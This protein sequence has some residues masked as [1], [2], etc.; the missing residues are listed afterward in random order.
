MIDYLSDETDCRLDLE[1]EHV[2]CSDL[3]AL[4]FRRFSGKA[5]H[6]MTAGRINT[7]ISW[8]AIFVVSKRDSWHLINRNGFFPQ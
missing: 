3:V 6:T 2:S 7:I 1:E 8:D 5:R 4:I